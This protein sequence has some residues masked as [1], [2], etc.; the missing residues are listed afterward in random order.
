[1]SPMS[2]SE[3]DHNMEEWN[4]NEMLRETHNCYAYAVKGVDPKLI[5]ECKET[6]DCN[7]GF[8]QPGYASGYD[9][10]SEQKGKGCTDMFSR[11]KGDNPGIQATTF[12][13]KCPYG[14]SKI[15]LILDRKRDY[16]FLKQASNGMWYHKPG[17]M[18]VTNLDS[19][20]RPILRPDRAVYM[21]TKH[22]NPL[23]Y[24]KMC[25]YY[26]VPRNTDIKIMTKVR[27]GGALPFSPLPTPRRQT[28][29]KSRDVSH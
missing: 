16:H 1:M 8:P 13:Q 4:N 2:G 18:E 9:K 7:V 21:Y 15:I 19:S 26:C 11:M 17:A 6:K 10:F 23:T 24:T 22:K 5:Q 27:E 28:R 20:D 14:T 12:E 3:P 29:R 25:G